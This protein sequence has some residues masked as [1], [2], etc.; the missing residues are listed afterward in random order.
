M[1]EGDG[2]A[3]SQ[4]Q[5]VFLCEPEAFWLHLPLAM[6]PAGEQWNSGFRG[7]WH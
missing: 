6:A 2:R 5:D 3:L 7:V 1:K 4:T